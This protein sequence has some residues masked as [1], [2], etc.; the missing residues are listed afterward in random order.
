MAAD[1][2]TARP[3]RKTYPGRDIEV[4]FEA[5]RCLHAAECVGG[6]PAVFDTAR[7]PWITPEAADADQVAEV[8]RRC[9]SGALTYRFTDGTAETPQQPTSV[10]RTASGQLAVRGDLAVET[11]DGPRRETRALLCGCAASARQPYCDHSGPCG[12]EG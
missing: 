10:A 4:T 12:Q 11:A 7:R 3:V 5:R 1:R 9:P 2:E 8:V 6:L